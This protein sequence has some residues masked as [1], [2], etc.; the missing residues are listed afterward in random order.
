MS[1][2]KN[3]PTPDCLGILTNVGDTVAV[4]T[5]SGKLIK[6][7]TVSKCTGKTVT[8][9]NGYD[10]FRSIQFININ[11]IVLQHPELFI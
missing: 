4:A 11:A 10:T 6:V 1:N 9:E 2:L 8:I 3:K 7:G 5:K